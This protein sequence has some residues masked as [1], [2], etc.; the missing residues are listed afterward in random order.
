MWPKGA[1]RSIQVKYLLCGHFTYESESVLHSHVAPLLSFWSTVQ[2]PTLLSL[3]SALTPPLLPQASGGGVSGWGPPSTLT[4]AERKQ[5]EIC[6]A[7]EED[8][9]DLW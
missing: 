3:S 8:T 2:V 5:K 4:T 7:L 9:G 1:G 6:Q